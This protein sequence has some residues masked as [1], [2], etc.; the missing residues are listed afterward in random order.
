LASLKATNGHLLCLDNTG[1]I[2][3]HVNFRLK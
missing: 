2:V 1:N 3:S